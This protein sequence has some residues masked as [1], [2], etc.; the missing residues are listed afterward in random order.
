MT[1]PGPRPERVR[2]TGPSRRR[3]PATRSSEIDDDTRL[4]DMYLGSLIREQLRLALGILTVLALTV[5]LL[6][7]VFHLLPGLA[8]QH[9]LGLPLSWLVLG[10][11]VYP[12]LVLLGWRYIRRS[13]A[14]ERDFIELV[15]A[16]PP[17]QRDATDPS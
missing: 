7:L 5:G 2:V 9:L 15:S 3:A 4:G 13:E 6:P 11:L 8:S 14:N 12:V 10:T 1:D 17:D 16:L